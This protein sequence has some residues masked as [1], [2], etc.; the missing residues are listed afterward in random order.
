MSV[1]RPAHPSA[2]GIGEVLFRYR[3]YTPVPLV[4]LILIC[5]KPSAFL[6]TLGVLAVAAGELIR[7]YS[8]AFIGAISRTRKDHTGPR[9]ITEGPFGM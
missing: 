5:A 2:V 4:L 6:A 9:L 8:V 7:V 1:N 3:D